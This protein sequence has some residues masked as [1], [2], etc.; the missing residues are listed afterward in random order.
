LARRK[1]PRGWIYTLGSWPAYF[2]L[3]LLFTGSVQ[4]VELLVGADCALVCAHLTARLRL[5]GIIPSAPG[6]LWLRRFPRMV[7]AVAKDSVLIFHHLFRCLNGTRREGRFVALPFQSRQK[8]ADGYAERAWIITAMT[9][10]PN[11]IV[12]AIDVERERIL[13]HQLVPGEDAA[14]AIEAI[15]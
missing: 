13:L 11:L 2:G 7:W 6:L 14:E 8:G 15:R 3:W 9:F 4:W 1:E 5:E 12:V 10:S